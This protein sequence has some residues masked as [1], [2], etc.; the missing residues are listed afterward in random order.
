MILASPRNFWFR[1]LVFTFSK[2]L[3]VPQSNESRAVLSRSDLGTGTPAGCMLLLVAFC[4][5]KKHM[6]K[7]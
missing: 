6:K 7:L 2:D 3:C 5:L 4:G 1:I